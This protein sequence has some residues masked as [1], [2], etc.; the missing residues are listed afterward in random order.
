MASEE[1]M[2]VMSSRWWK[3]GMVKTTKMVAYSMIPVSALD[4]VM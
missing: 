2:R 4:H 1:T 3:K